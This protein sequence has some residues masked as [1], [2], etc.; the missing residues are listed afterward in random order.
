[1]ALRLT[2]PEPHPAR[3]S[4]RLTLE[5][6]RPADVR[7]EVLD[8]AGRR[9]RPLHSG[10]TPAGALALTWDGLRERGRGMPSGLYFIRATSGGDNA[11]GRVLIAPLPPARAAGSR[12]RDRG[13]S[14]SS[15]TRGRSSSPWS[16]RASRPARLSPRPRANLPPSGPSRSARP[17]TRSWR[18]SPPQP[19]CSA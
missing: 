18:R 10:A 9:V 12:P 2:A 16:G 14:P 4:V 6:P 11:G 8:L 17:R 1:R 19:A 7:V 13:T 15:R 3:G 5:L